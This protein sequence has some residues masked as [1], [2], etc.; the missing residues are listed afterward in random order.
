MICITCYFVKKWTK[1]V[2]S[3]I[4]KVVWSESFEHSEHKFEVSYLTD[5]SYKLKRD[6]VEK[7]KSILNLTEKVLQLKQQISQVIIGKN[8]IV[9]MVFIALLNDGH[10]LLES[11]PGTGKTQL[12][13]S[14]AKTIDGS[15]KRIQ[16]TP[17]LL[18]SDVTGI[19]FFH[20]KEQ[21]FQLRIGPVMTNILLADEINRATPRTQ[22][23]L[24]EVM[25]ERQVTIDGETIALPKPFMVIATQNPIESQQGTFP[26]PE[27]QMDRF[28]MQIPLGYPTIE[29]EKKIMQTYR[30]GT[31]YNNLNTVFTLDE[32]TKLKEDVKQVS[33]SE[34]VEDYILEL[35]HLTR[36]HDEIEMGVSPRG[37]LAL[38][39]GAQGRAFLQ[40]RLFVTPQDVKDIAV[41]MLA[42]RLVLT[43]DASLKR[44]NSQVLETILKSVEVPAET[45]AL[46]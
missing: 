13:K 28:F 37:T 32:I 18:P 25:E 15:F 44:T 20:P 31:P 24:L 27:A 39:R 2:F 1:P 46:K 16:F 38:M 3:C 19:Q 33:I 43:L 11:V 6:K 34:D 42:H 30:N 29:E 45:G 23:S 21:D 8:D 36:N 35:V 5:Y 22:A 12:A 9:E 14:F 26:L 4:I 17:D 40:N 41:Y 10:V 7:G